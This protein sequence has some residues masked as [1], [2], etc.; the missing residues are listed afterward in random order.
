[1]SGEED[2]KDPKRGHQREHGSDYREEPLP[3]ATLASLG[4]VSSQN[5]VEKKNEQVDLDW[6]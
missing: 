2:G 6:A 3:C 1:L 5:T 4:A